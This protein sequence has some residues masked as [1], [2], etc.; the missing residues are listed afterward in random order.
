VLAL[1]AVAL[2]V[3]RAH[4]ASP[5]QFRHRA[6]S[7]N[8]QLIT[9]TS[10]GVG[11]V[12]VGPAA[13]TCRVVAKS[14]SNTKLFTN[15]QRLDPGNAIQMGVG[16]PDSQLHIVVTSTSAQRAN[17]CLPL[18]QIVDGTTFHT[19]VVVSDFAVVNKAIT[20]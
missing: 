3:G 16:R 4:G 12:N 2:L 14:L 6:T 7:S 17:P 19:D 11:I 9:G 20:P 8:V 10:M 18:I 5:T 13:V 15:S 1:L